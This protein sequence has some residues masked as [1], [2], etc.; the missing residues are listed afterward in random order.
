MSKHKNAPAEQAQ[1]LLK[2]NKKSTPEKDFE[3]ILAVTSKYYGEALT[4]LADGEMP[5]E[6]E[7][8]NNSSC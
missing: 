7:G 3:N 1:D 5:D 6:N 2:N 8:P 4:K